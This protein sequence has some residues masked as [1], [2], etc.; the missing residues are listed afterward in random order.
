MH[1]LFGS[2][3]QEIE[4]KIRHLNPDLRHLA[5][6]LSEPKGVALLEDGNQLSVALD[7]SRGDARLFRAALTRAEISAKE[8]MRFVSTGFR[9]EED[10][11]ETAKKLLQLAKSLHRHMTSKES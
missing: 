9:G 6:A 2:V 5:R 1:W 10:L 3:S 8:S 7:A 4:P 11:V